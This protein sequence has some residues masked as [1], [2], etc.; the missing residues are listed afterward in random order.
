[1]YLW[2]RR[3]CLKFRKA[4]YGD[5]SCAL[6]TGDIQTFGGIRARTSHLAIIYNYNK[7]C[8]PL[9]VDRKRPASAEECVDDVR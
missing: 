1:M 8:L 6:A 9:V 5:K 2:R 4:A 7:K 3:A